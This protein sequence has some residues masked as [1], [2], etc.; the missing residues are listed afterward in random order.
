M[1]EDRVAALLLP[2]EYLKDDS[3][4]AVVIRMYVDGT[5]IGLY[6][7]YVLMY[8]VCFVCAVYTVFTKVHF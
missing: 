4:K 1:E 6:E 2:S 7:K 3:R 5:Y 8:L